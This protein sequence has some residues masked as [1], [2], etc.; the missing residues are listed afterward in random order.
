M[1]Y[2]PVACEMRNSAWNT[3]SYRLVRVGRGP[4]KITSVLCTRASNLIT[5]D[6]LSEQTT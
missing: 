3:E 4:K 5:L 2:F 6:S 1:I